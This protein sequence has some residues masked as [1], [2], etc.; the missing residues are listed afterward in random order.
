M[1]TL[2]TRRF[3]LHNLLKP[4]KYRFCQDSDGV[5]VEQFAQIDLRVGEI[6][7]CEIVIIFVN[8]ASRV[9]QTVL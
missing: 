2:T 7:E 6:T 5:S 4:Q 1:I 8:S 9:R 3:A